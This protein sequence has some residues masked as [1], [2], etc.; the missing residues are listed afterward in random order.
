[1]HEEPVHRVIERVVSEGLRL[2]DG[3]T[4]GAQREM[5]ARDI[6]RAVC[7][8]LHP[9]GRIAVPSATDIDAAEAVGDRNRRIRT[10]FDGRNHLALALRFHLST[11]QIRR[12]VERK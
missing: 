1:M 8:E 10:A 4:G 2:V 12:I 6:A 9:R 5:V 7:D 11:R 3:R